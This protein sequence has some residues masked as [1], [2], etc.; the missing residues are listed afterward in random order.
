MRRI[1]VRLNGVATFIG[2][3]GFVVVVFVL[4]ILLA[5]FFTG[6][7]EDENDDVEFIAGKTSLG[8]AVDVQNTTGSVYL[9]ELG[10]NFEAFSLILK[11]MY[12]GKEMCCCWG[13]VFKPS[14]L[15]GNADF[16]LFNAGQA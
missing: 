10:M 5:R 2:I 1:T 3:V 15:L 4:V 8:N 14:K 12:T 13:Q 7:T 16:H 6:H 9:P 11:F